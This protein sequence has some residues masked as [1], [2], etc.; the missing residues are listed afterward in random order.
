MA[1]G[2]VDIIFTGK[3]AEDFK[4]F[5]NSRHVM[6]ILEEEVG[7]ATLRNIL[8]MQDAIQRRI[9]T[10]EFKVKNTLVTI[11]IKGTGKPPLVDVG[12][13]HDAILT[14]LKHSFLGYVGILKAQRTSHGMRMRMKK[15]AMFLEKGFTVKLTERMRNW[16]FAQTRGSDKKGGKGRKQ[17]DKRVVG[18]LRVPPRPFI[19]PIFRSKQMQARFNANWELATKITLKRLKAI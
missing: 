18:K 6:R 5:T 10:G 16:L 7:K 12:D 19:T 13:L 15:L 3:G 8:I 1:A 9:R 17:G 11:K 4:K 14:E 2:T